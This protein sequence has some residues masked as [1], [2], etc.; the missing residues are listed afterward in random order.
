M[1][2]FHKRHNK[3]KIKSEYTSLF[4]EYP[5]IFNISLSLSYD[6]NRLKK[7]LVLAKKIKKKE[8][9]EHAASVQVGQIL[10]DEI[11]KPQL[12]TK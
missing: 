2:R 6:F 7:M 12:D 11:V 9:T 8:I 5:A 10:V 4:N 3:K 1:E